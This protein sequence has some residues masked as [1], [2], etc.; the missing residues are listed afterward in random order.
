MAD[1]PEPDA[2]VAFGADVLAEVAAHAIVA[3]FRTLKNRVLQETDIERI[4]NSVARRLEEAQVVPEFSRAA[5]DHLL[6]DSNLRRELS[7]R[8]VRPYIGGDDELVAMFARYVGPAGDLSAV[9]FAKVVVAEI[10]TVLPEVLSTAQMIDRAPFVAERDA[11]LARVLGEAGDKQA[12]RLRRMTAAAVDEI[13]AVALTA[14]GTIRLSRGLYVERGPEASVLEALAERASTG[15]I[16]VKADAGLGKSSLLWRLQALLANTR[17]VEPLLIKATLL[18]GRGAL[19]PILAPADLAIGV[20]AIA[21]SGT[22]PVLMLDTVDSLVDT[23]GRDGVEDL[24]TELLT[25]C[26]LVLATRPQEAGQLRAVAATTVELFPYPADELHRIV[27][28]H[29]EQFPLPDRYASATSAADDVVAAAANGLPIREVLDNPLALRMLLEV[30]RGDIS[31]EMNIAGVY[32]AYWRERVE[33]DARAGGEVTGGDLSTTARAAAAALAAAGLPDVPEESLRADV[34]A[35]SGDVAELDQLVDRGILV[36]SGGG[37]LGD[38]VVRFFHQTYLEY[39]AGRALAAGG[40]EAIRAVEARVGAHGEDLFRAPM[41]QQALLVAER[42]APLPTRME[43]NA[44]LLR[45]L[46]SGRTV[47]E[48]SGLIVYCFRRDIEPATHAT[49]LE[50]ASVSPAAASVIALHAAGVTPSRDEQIIELLGKVWEAGSWTDRK[51]VLDAIGRFAYRAARAVKGFLEQ[52]DVVAT[53]TEHPEGSVSEGRTIARAAL[54]VARAGGARPDWALDFLDVLWRTAAG[55]RRSRR[56]QMGIAEL[57]AEYAEALALDD[58]A[59]WLRGLML[60]E[61]TLAG[62]RLV[63]LARSWGGAWRAQWRAGDV[64]LDGVLDEILS[65][66]DATEF[67]GRLEGFR[68]WLADAHEDDLPRVLEAFEREPLE[69]KHEW[70]DVVFARLLA[71]PDTAVG[72]WMADLVR[73][74]VADAPP[75]GVPRADARNSVPAQLRIA[76]RAAKLTPDALARLLEGAAG[77]DDPRLWLDRE[78]IFVHFCAPAA[79]GGHRGAGEALATLLANPE[80]N[81]QAAAAAR[82]KLDELSRYDVRGATTFVKLCLAT[83]AYGLLAERIVGLHQRWPVEML[84]PLG[85]VAQVAIRLRDEQNRGRQLHGLRLSAALAI[86]GVDPT[87]E[88]SWVLA[89]LEE[90]S[91]PPALQAL[92]QLLGR[93]RIEDSEVIHRAFDEALRYA[94]ADDESVREAAL[95][96]ASDLGRRFWRIL[97]T[98]A[99]LRVAATEPRTNLRIAQVGHVVSDLATSDVGAATSLLID[100]VGLISSAEGSNSLD[101]DVAGRVQTA[102]WHVNLAAERGDRERLLRAAPGAPLRMATAIVSGAALLHPEDSQDT[103]RELLEDEAVHVRVRN[104][105]ADLLYDRQRRAGSTPWPELLEVLG[106]VPARAAT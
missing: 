103:L 30:A 14:A 4:F 27:V 66:T 92:L 21:A 56:L 18:A 23:V 22:P 60:D 97:G 81:Q 58:P 29:M 102:V 64:S 72:A 33:R 61:Q 37:D 83:E 95:D 34:V 45:L 10:E 69:R 42:D 68:L 62:T 77:L 17:E 105:I 7:S 67:Q 36:R 49:A 40:A 98:D 100:L 47:D 54:D 20:Q 84:A 74:R 79:I 57:I 31:P 55:A 48:R 6:A 59:D 96:A 35:L 32:T 44:C 106:S 1:A 39:A 86:A 88:G 99:A 19:P 53:V 11:Q 46:R 90:T 41:L 26:P 63:E 13:D 51:R 85:A 101:R 52:E 3:G 91:R 65:T 104:L 2:T 25:Y 71:Q 5:Y 89:Q 82:T 73:R 8:L 93:S 76:L 70:A 24:V 43:A 38:R 50:L 75:A 87:T 80:A 16:V 12:R 28:R 15:A 94:A 9:E 78:M